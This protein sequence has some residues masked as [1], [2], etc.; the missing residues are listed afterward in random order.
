M[1]AS[2]TVKQYDTWPVWKLTLSD[3]NGPIDLTNA[4]SVKLVG[5]GNKNATPIG[6]T[7]TIAQKSFTGTLTN[8]NNTVSAV[9]SFTGLAVGQTITGPDIPAGTTITALNSGAATL[10]MSATATA[11]VTGAT[12]VANQGGITY[13]PTVTDTG[14]V[15]T[16]PLE[17]AIHWAAGGVQKVPNS[18]TA[19]PTLEV[20]QDLG[21]AT[22]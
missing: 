6:G 12:L 4:S 3:A 15:D 16:Y 17:A 7:A 20:D 13:T 19:N 10:T 1:A 5:L 8:N 21:G 18:Y 9:S 14:T 2:L 22:E 11:S